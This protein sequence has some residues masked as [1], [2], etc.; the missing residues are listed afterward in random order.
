MRVAIF[1]DT[2]LPQINGVATSSSNLFKA[3]KSHG[4]EAV[5]V[6]TNPFDNEFS[7]EDGIMRIPGLEIKKLYGYIGAW[8]WNSAAMKQ[9]EKFHPDVIHVQTEAGVGQFGFLSSLKLHCAT[10]YTFHT[11]MEDYAYYFTHGFFDRAARGV[12]RGY[13]R[14]EIMQ[15]D[16]FVTPSVKIQE[17]M[18]SIGVDDRIN[19]IPT[20]IDFSKFEK[21][22]LDPE[23]LAALKSKC[24]IDKG[25]YV[26]LSLGRVA[27]EKSIDVC[28][29]GYAKFLTTHPERKTMFLLVGGGPALP[30]LIKLARSLGLSGHFVSTGPVPPSEVAYYYALGDCFVSASIT[31][32]QGLTFMEAMAASLVLLCRYD[33]TLLGTI[34]DGTNG[35]FFSDEDDFA[36]KLPGIISLPASKLE[37]IRAEER[38]SNEPYSI[39]RFYESLLEVYKRAIRK[40]W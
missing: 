25:T 40:N 22:S 15:A 10:V 24:G 38:K 28:L 33:D 34:K 35:Y 16:E 13:V 32:T 26:V 36:E 3:L 39:N 11:M 21:K 30:E 5:V 7:F 9:L 8:L 37:T 29:R 27:K 14:Y 31:E 1:T 6:T 2:Y 23:K 12:V 18:R 20:G 4:H 17:Y 19:V